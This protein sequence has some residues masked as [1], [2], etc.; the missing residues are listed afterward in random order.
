MGVV[1]PELHHLNVNEVYPRQAI[2]GFQLAPDG[3]RFA[4]VCQRDLR[5][6]E[7]NDRDGRK[8]QGT[9]VADIGFLANA[10]GYPQQ[11]TTSGDFTNPAIWS[12]D[13]AWLT[14]EHGEGLL[15][16][17]ADG[18]QRRLVYRGKLHHPPVPQAPGAGATG[19]AQ[20][21]YPRWSP[22]GA[23]ILI[24]VREQ[25]QT[26]LR[27]VRADGKAQ[28]DVFAL[29]GAIIGWDWSPDGRRIVCVTRNE[30]GWTGD[31]QVIDV[32]S[33]E[34]RVL[35]QENHYAYLMPVAAWASD[36][37]IVF[38][39][40]RSGWAKL[41]IASADGGEVTPLSSGSWDD[42]AFRVSPTG[43]HV[44]YASRAAQPGSGDDLWI[45]P[46]AG[47]EPVRLTRHGGINAPLAWSRHGEIFYWH[48]GPTE[49]GDVW[50]VSAEGGPSRRLTWSTPIDL[51]RKLLA[52]QEVVIEN[53][54]VAIPTLIYLPTYFQ[55]GEQYPAIVWIHGGPTMVARADFA[56]Y[57]NWLANQGYVV[58]VPNYRG[59]V[60]YGVA[61]MN[62]VAGDGVGKNDL[63]DV[64]AAAEHIRTLPY[65]DL[66]RGVG[67]GGRSWG[68]YL[69]LMAVTQASDAFSCA[70][71]DAAISDW[72]VQQAKTEV[73]YY[74]HWLMGGWVYEQSELAGDRSPINS[75]ARLKIP[76]LV[77]HG[78]DDASVP[79]SQI[80]TFVARARQAGAAVDLASYPLEGHSNRKPEHQQDA[81][82]R[83]RAFFCRHLQ[84]WNLRDNPSG[85][86]TG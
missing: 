4:F 36:T 62:A 22:D 83:T 11:L 79:F 60:G 42:Y 27:L 57:C 48:A 55:P 47:G 78:E 81:L 20:W 16:M 13:G 69:T 80:E 40:N 33:G 10:G 8:L 3:R 12:P 63:S 64:L 43:E 51:A 56:P 53:E 66:T 7:I 54:G 1:S 86:Q 31:I 37:Q 14:C 15:V 34:T 30:D 75:V 17:A 9:P 19:E 77:L 5:V 65:V 21:G 49:R 82:E 6:A 76:L 84:A 74:D 44:V 41:W 29:D 35:C 32:Q 28:R 26:I 73:R 58:M 50:A 38:R 71:A 72:F 85:H 61:H 68:G 67:V 23:S 18:S 39:S 45:V 2:F 70:L 59:S 25:F 52:P 24:A 46:S